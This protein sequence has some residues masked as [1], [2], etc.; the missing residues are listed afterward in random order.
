MVTIEPV[1]AYGLRLVCVCV[2]VCVCVRVCVYMCVCVCVCVFTC[3]IACVCVCHGPHWFF[4]WWRRLA[5][6]MWLQFL[7]QCGEWFFS[8][9]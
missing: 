6:F 4:K 7:I 2:C 8:A 5:V 9:A 3:V 1:F